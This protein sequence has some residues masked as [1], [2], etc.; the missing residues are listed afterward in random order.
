MCISEFKGDK[1]YK[2]LERELF[3]WNFP[4]NLEVLPLLEFIPESTQYVLPIYCV[5]FSYDFLG[6]LMSSASICF[7]M[8]K[9]L[10]FGLLRSSP[11][12][13]FLGRIEIATESSIDP[14]DGVLDRK[15][16]DLFLLSDDFAGKNR[17]SS[18]GRGDIAVFVR[19]VDFSC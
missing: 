14:F 7:E 4:C 6:L 12:D 3:L 11:E 18:D 13:Y 9:L 1:N 10:L 17:K 16:S 15:A 19:L 8:F 2:V 5:M